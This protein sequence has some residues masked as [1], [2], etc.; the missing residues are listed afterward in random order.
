MKRPVTR[1]RSSFG[2][3]AWPRTRRQQVRSLSGLPPA[4]G[5]VAQCGRA[6][7]RQGG[8]TR[9]E[10]VRVHHASIAQ[11]E[12]S[13]GLRCRRPEVRVLVGAPGRGS[14]AAERLF[15]RQL[16]VC[17]THT[18]ATTLR[19]EVML[20]RRSVRIQVA[21]RPRRPVIVFRFRGRLLV[22]ARGR[23]GRSGGQRGHHCGE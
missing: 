12:Q 10:P 13:A 3:S 17:S 22:L 23:V 6:P 9:F 2:Q 4:H 11:V 5:P 1:P 7:P 20:G 8:G 16:M 21:R 14:S 15:H 18:P 19:K